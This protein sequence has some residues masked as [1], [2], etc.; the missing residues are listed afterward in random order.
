MTTFSFLLIDPARKAAIEA[1]TAARKA[2]G[3]LSIVQPIAFPD[4]RCV[5]NW[6]IVGETAAGR[7]FEAWAAPIA[8]AAADPANK[9]TLSYAEIY[10]LQSPG[11]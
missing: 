8:S 2:A 10:A 9:V 1:I 4:G 3:A 7:Q 11:G 6:D 5:L